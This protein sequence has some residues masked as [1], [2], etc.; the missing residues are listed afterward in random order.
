MRDTQAA[1]ER[2]RERHDTLVDKTTTQLRD[3]EQ[4]NANS[5]AY[6]ARIEDARTGVENAK[7][8]AE[9]APVGRDIVANFRGSNVEK[10]IPLLPADVV[11]AMPK[12]D[13]DAYAR[14]VTTSYSRLAK[15]PRAP[16]PRYMAMG[17]GKIHKVWTDKD[18]K[19]H[20]DIIG[21][22][23]VKP[24]KDNSD[25]INAAAPGLAS[26]AATPA[27]SNMPPSPAA[28]LG[29]APKNLWGKTVKVGDKTYKIDDAGNVTPAGGPEG[30]S[31]AP[32]G[33]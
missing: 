3:I 13:A 32:G 29:T 12:K 30:G 28:P 11:A 19:D 25:L 17:D 27:P 20:D 10:L 18:G 2:E 26:P 4:Q 16:A 24:G 6:R 21:P 31:P 14:D 9:I 15:D 8:A 1:T 33:L 22:A 5:N 23:V 7:D